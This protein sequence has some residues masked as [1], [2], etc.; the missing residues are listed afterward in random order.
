MNPPPTAYPSRRHPPIPEDELHPSA[1]AP[2]PPLTEA[3]ERERA[4]YIERNLWIALVG[5]LLFALAL[6]G[7]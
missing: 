7:T 4:A 6:L 5:L 1:D 3:E 2:P